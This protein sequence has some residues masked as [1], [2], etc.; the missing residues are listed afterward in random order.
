M[1]EQSHEDVAIRWRGEFYCSCPSRASSNRN[2][3]SALSAL[4]FLLFPALFSEDNFKISFA[5]MLEAL[6]VINLLFTGP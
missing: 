1:K 5:E 3:A 2:T 6:D 4:A